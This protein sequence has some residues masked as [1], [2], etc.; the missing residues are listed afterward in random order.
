[1]IILFQLPQKENVNKEIS[2]NQK[3]PR[4][5]IKDIEEIQSSETSILQMSLN[6]STHH[7]AS[8]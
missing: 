7:G 2:R 1:M 4:I 6:I 3:A 5:L 8:L